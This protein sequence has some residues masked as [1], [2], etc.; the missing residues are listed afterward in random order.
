[1]GIVTNPSSNG[2]ARAEY[3][4]LPTAHAE[5]ASRETQDTRIMRVY[6]V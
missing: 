6:V 2:I 3:H 4:I 5:P 1:M